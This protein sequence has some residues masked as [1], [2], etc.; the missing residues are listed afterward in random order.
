MNASKSACLILPAG[1]DPETDV[2]S[3]SA[4]RALLL[5]A[6]LANTL[7]PET[8]FSDTISVFSGIV[9]TGVGVFTS[10]FLVDLFFPVLIL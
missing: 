10:T 9:L 2:R 7:P 1:P 3:K 5:T 8:F 6:G 4:S